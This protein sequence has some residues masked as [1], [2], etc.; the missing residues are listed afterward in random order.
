MILID[1]KAYGRGGTLPGRI[2][3]VNGR[4]SYDQMLQALDHTDVHVTEDVIRDEHLTGVYDEDLKT[5]LIDSRMTNVQKRCTLVH[6][7]VHW[8]HG[9]QGCSSWL[10]QHE[11]N[12]AQQETALLL[13][14]PDAYRRAEHE[15][16][17]DPYSMA[18]QL[19]VTM[20]VLN[21]YQRML[22]NGLCGCS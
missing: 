3:P 1:H 22:H 7:L 16:D 5:I 12:R 10:G 18:C 9:D 20:F 8:K 13:I 17:A 19:D 6:E 15:C 11:E 21:T 4:M 14:S 2:M